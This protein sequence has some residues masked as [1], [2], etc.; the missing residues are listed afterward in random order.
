MKK[1]VSFVLILTSLFHL[2][3]FADEAEKIISSRLDQA[4]VFLQGAELTHVATTT[5]TNGGNEIK[6]KNLSPN[7]DKNSLKIKASNGVLVSAF[8][9]S[10]DEI[11]TKKPN[12]AKVQVKK[13][14]LDTAIDQLDRLKAEIKIDQEL[15]QI[16]KKGIDRNVSDTLSI[17]D[18]VKIMEYY[19][20]KSSEIEMR[21]ISNRKRQTDLERSIN[22]LKQRI[23]IESSSEYERS[24]VLRINCTAPLSTNCTFSISY[25]T[26][27]AQWTPFYDINITSTSKPVKIISKAKVRQTT[28]ID[29][30][31]VK[32]VLSTA[33]PSNG[34]TAPLF[35]AWFLRYLSSETYLNAG[36][37]AKKVAQN[38]Y[39]YRDSELG[40]ESSL[41]GDYVINDKKNSIMYVVNGNV[42]DE[43]YYNSL[44]PSM[45]KDVT[46]LSG[47]E[48]IA[49]YGQNASSGVIVVELKNTMEDYITTK[50]NDL[51]LTFNIDLPYTI[52]GNGKE[53][54]IDLQTKEVNANYKYYCAPKL[55]TETYLLAEIPEWE[56]LNLLQGKANITYDGTYVGETSIAPSSTQKNLSLTLGTDKRVSVK[57]ELVRD[58]N[59][60][61]STGGGDNK[62][63]FT[64]KITVKNNQTKPI[65]MVL[66][67]QYPKSTQKDIEVEL[68]QKETT[69]PSFN[70]EETGVLTW[71][72]DFGAGES[73]TYQIS[74]SVKYPKGQTI[75]L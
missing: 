40:L 72:D 62:Q 66:K 9:F 47:A 2:S 43:N 54:M 64:Y 12:S 13:D 11:P 75:N 63:M 48:A 25:Y 74:Y 10:V 44:N 31:K 51:N 67:D 49:K 27:S 21:Q 23:L 70:M 50:E 55:D 20:K 45:I 4:T 34:K 8:E 6:I 60:S 18:L 52:P 33:T 73:K 36:I 41:A 53:Q 71:E 39:S 1:N 14:S 69:T 61:K 57:R 32:L 38:S 65:K 42:V 24:G 30:S 26:P 29:W 22:E 37:R 59:L 5:L 68:L 28:T 56:K 35:S 15:S 7:I 16:M 19:Q 3:V 17:N 58:N 46:T